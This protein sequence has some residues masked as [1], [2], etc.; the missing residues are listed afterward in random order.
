MGVAWAR[1]R[2]PALQPVGGI[3]ALDADVVQAGDLDRRGHPRLAR[4]LVG[5]DKGEEPQSALRAGGVHRVAV[6]AG[7]FGHP[8]GG[9]RRRRSLPVGLDPQGRARVAQTASPK[10]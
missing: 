1:R 6:A 2:E 4:G 5:P 7:A 9:K 3:G 8:R 10:R